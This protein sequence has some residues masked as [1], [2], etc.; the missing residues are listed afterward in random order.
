MPL[1]YTIFSHK[2]RCYTRFQDLTALAHLRYHLF[3]HLTNKTALV[4]ATKIVVKQQLLIFRTVA[5]DNILVHNVRNEILRQSFGVN[6][7][8]T[9]FLQVFDEIR[10]GAA[11]FAFIVQRLE[12][13]PP[14]ALVKIC[15]LVRCLPPVRL[16][17]V[18]LL[19]YNRDFFS[20]TNPPH[21]KISFFSVKIGNGGNASYPPCSLILRTKSL[22]RNM[23]QPVRFKRF[24]QKLH[25]STEKTQN[26]HNG[27]FFRVLLHNTVKHDIIF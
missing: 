26:L 12:I 21:N 27:Q 18:I 8:F 17:T 23:A 4:P 24:R 10:Y 1:L 2:S 19:L 13:A 16:E 7:F 25:F 20:K 22:R 6:Y 14:E 11:E 3:T 15:V 5:A 9:R